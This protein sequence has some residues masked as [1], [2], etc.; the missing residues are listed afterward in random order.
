MKKT[1]LASSLAVGLGVTGYALT[2]GNEAHASEATNYSHLANLAQNNPSELNA[3][4]VQAGAYDISFVK[5]G[6]K[7]SFTSNGSSWSWNYVYA[8]GA[9]S[10]FYSEGT[11]SNVSSNTQSSSSDVEAVS[12]PT[13]SSSSQSSSS[14][15]SYSTTTTSS[16]S[17]SSSSSASSSAS[18]SYTQRAAALMAQR[19]GV[20]AA[21]WAKIISRESGGNLNA[22]NPSGASGL[23]QTMPGW[24]DTSTF[25]GQINAAVKA[26]NAQGLS[27]WSETNY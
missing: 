24:G 16:S 21:T 27:A 23:L 14:H 25:E 22:Y 4:P 7:Y 5:D 12:A 10:E 26:Y 20:S 11:S 6:F 9:D 19:T 13:T 3:H 2:S 15:S 17:S 18:G 8:G 1:I